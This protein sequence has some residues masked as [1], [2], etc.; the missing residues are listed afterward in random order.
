MT[1]IF[2]EKGVILDELLEKNTKIIYNDFFDKNN[3]NF[4]NLNDIKIDHQDINKQVINLD[5]LKNIKKIKLL[6][7]RLY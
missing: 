7:M 4:F 1:K 6:L 5:V 2:Y 3:T